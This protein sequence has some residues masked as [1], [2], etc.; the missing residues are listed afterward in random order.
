MK[1]RFVFA[2][3]ATGEIERSQMC[4]SG[5]VAAAPDEVYAAHPTATSAT[6]CWS[7]STLVEY[8]PEEQARKA[9]RPEYSAFWD[10]EARSWI[11]LRSL[12]QVKR[13]RAKPLL[14]EIAALE[15]DQGRGAREAL[16]ALLAGTAPPAAA[17]E[18]L[19]AVDAAIAPLRAKVQA[20][21]AAT[22][23]PALDAI[24]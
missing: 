22:T 13:D 23:R 17:V 24:P 7:G 4:A 11:D 10:N 12:E 9:V 2:N 1:Q 3:A 8:T 21:D 14:A 15:A 18:R 19:A 20:I 5:A 16:L 6:H